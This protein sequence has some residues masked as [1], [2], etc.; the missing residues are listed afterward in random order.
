MAGGRKNQSAT[1]LLREELWLHIHL[2]FLADDGHQCEYAC[3]SARRHAHLRESLPVEA[4]LGLHMAEVE[5]YAKDAREVP[6]IRDKRVV[7]VTAA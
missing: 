5:C 7:A 1:P 3:A 2:F 4:C 6:Q